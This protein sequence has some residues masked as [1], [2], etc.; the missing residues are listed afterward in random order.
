M[1]K[2]LFPYGKEEIEYSFKEMKYYI[3]ENNALVGNKEIL[4]I[5]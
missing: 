1:K 2:V 4:Q 5:S 3:A